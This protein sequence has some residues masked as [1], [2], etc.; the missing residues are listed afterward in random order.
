MWTRLRRVKTDSFM[1]GSVLN[2]SG[3]LTYSR[4]VGV[5]AGWHGGR[6]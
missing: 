5:L 3:K 6:L 4:L 1:A 2:L